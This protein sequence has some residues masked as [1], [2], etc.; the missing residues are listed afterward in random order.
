MKLVEVHEPSIGTPPPPAVVVV[1]A[2]SRDLDASDPRGWR[3]GGGVTYSAMALARLGVSVG[4]VVGV[5]D[6]AATASELE[7]LRGA[8][9]GVRQ[10][11]LANGPVF[12]NRETGGRRRQVAHS[13]ADAIPSSALP[14]AWRTATC[15][16]LNPVAGELGDAWASVPAPTALV[17]LGWQG[18]LR[19]LVPGQPVEAL[20]IALSPLIE[21][22]DIATVSVE[23][24]SG[25]AD[26]AM[27]ALLPRVGQQLVVTR[28]SG[29]SLHLRRDDGGWRMRSAPVTP[30]REV[31]D[32]TGAG[33]VFIAAWLSGVLS[34][35]AAGAPHTDDWRALALAGAA[36][37]AKV[38]AGSLVEMPDRAAICARLLRPPGATRERG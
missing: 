37:G 25:G 22:A 9:V 15:F 32:P 2:A 12:D 24:A 13:P 26:E 20:P 18:L 3:L 1:G 38:E 5:D 29:I 16:L 21:R 31:R 8:G 10:V 19:R 17:A 27:F 11:P 36:A 30:A 23:D 34:L 6:E 33:D 4:A 28:D 35:R 14:A 7:V